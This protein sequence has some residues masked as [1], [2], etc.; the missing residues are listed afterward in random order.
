[1]VGQYE[2]LTL[3]RDLAVKTLEASVAN[4]ESAR[5]E[6]RRKQ[7]YL[8][9]VVNPNRPDKAEEPKRL[10]TVFTVLLAS[11]VAYGTLSL[12]IAGLREHRQQ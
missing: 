10:R 6:A 8:E 3:E 2:Q 7:L 9:R 1:M 12:I 11:L 5:M 4:L